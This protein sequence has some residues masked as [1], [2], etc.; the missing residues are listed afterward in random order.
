MNRHRAVAPSVLCLQGWGK[1]A[2]PN[3]RAGVASKNPFR[4]TGREVD[5]ESSLYFM[6]A[7]YFDPATGRFVSEDPARFPG[8]INFYTYVE[9]DPVDLVDPFGF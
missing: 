8:G 1:R 5:S 7:R 3:V 4:F 6:R 9:N 2:V